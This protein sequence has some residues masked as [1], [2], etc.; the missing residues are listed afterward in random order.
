[1]EEKGSLSGETGSFP[2]SLLFSRRVSFHP[3]HPSLALPFWLPSFRLFS[4]H[5]QPPTTLLWTYYFL[6]LHYAHPTSNPSPSPTTS[7][8]LLSKAVDHTP[9]LPELFTAKARVLKHAGD[10][11]GAAVQMEE[12]RRL[13]G[14]DRFLNSKA[15]KYWLR[16]GQEERALGVLGLFTKVRPKYLFSDSLGRSGR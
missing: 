2:L 3:T 12:A 5:L 6:S 11:W 1:M 16:A 7:L 14:Q 9:T 13:D 4:D 10:S 8:S 15:G